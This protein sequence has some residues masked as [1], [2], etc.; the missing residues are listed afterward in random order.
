VIVAQITDMHVKMRGHV[1]PH[2][3]HVIG[4]LRRALASIEAMCARPDCILATGDLTESGRFEEYLRL[5]EIVD[6]IDI[7]VYLLPGN[8]DY[9]E[10]IRR[11]FPDRDYL[12]GADEAVQFVVEGAAMRV[13][14]IDSS[15]APRQ[16]GYLDAPRLRWLEERLNERP[17][18]PTI[19]AMHHP[20][21]RTGVRYFDQQR[22][23]GK[24]ALASIVR[25]NPQ[26][27]RIA[28]GHLHQTISHTWSG[29]I[30]VSA[31]ST[32]PTIVLHPRRMGFS[33]EGGGFLVHRYDRGTIATEL[34]RLPPD[35]IA[36]LIGVRT[37]RA[38][39]AG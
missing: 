18:T 31:P 23:E 3:P 9:R 35:P 39:K 34:V 11:A 12:R 1:L 7:P 22:F 16:G 24:K 20:P 2:M 37:P 38:R 10:A 14:A 13:V 19:L 21:F 32:A 8:H 15:E 4:P 29:T 26:I 5:R 30:A 17:K 25:A 27:L 28:C 36:D 33:L 6:A